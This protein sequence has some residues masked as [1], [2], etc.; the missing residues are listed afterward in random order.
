MSFRITAK[1]EIRVWKFDGYKCIQ[2]GDSFEIDGPNL[3]IS[4]MKASIEK[5]TGKKLVSYGSNISESDWLI[6]KI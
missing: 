6:E 5:K 2:K 3:N 4:A 1:K